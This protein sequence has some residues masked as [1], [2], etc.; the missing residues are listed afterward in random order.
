M[1]SLPPIASLR[2][3]FTAALTIACLNQSALAQQKP[4]VT[5]VTVTATLEAAFSQQIVATDSPTAF[6]AT[7]LPPGLSV[8]S[9]GVIS[10]TPTRAGLFSA[11]MIA[12]NAQGQGEATL[13]LT[14]KAPATSGMVDRERELFITKP[15]ILVK[16]GKE[17]P[18][19][20]WSFRA[21]MGRLAPKGADVN[22]FA[23]TWFDT[24]HLALPEMRDTTR[25]LLVGA[26]DDTSRNRFRLIGLV[27]RMDLGKFNSGDLTQPVALGESRLVYEVLQDNGSPSTFTFIFEFGLLGGA[28]AVKDTT[29]WALRW[30]ALGRASL[31]ATD[32]LD[33]YREELDGVVMDY[34]LGNGT[35]VKSRLNQI[36]TNEIVG[37]PWQ[38][39]EFHL[40]PDGS[41]IE[42][43]SVALT[44]DK[45]SSGT[46]ALAAYINNNATR[47]INGDFPL[48]L[49]PAVPMGLKSDSDAL[50][51]A[52]GVDARALFIFA[53]NTCGGCHKS[54]V[55]GMNF[56]HLGSTNA[57]NGSPFVTGSVT[58]PQKL[59]G[60]TS[61]VHDE[62][63]ERSTILSK[64]ALDP[65]VTFKALDAANM[66]TARKGRVH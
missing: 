6:A 10:G 65:A 46:A 5:P 29:D 14:V 63:A 53:F 45:I 8:N 31:K 3:C 51:N 66:L 41:R 12:I 59:P 56:Q 35:T 64:L 19:D 34:S 16:D 40:S 57:A 23:K 60:A 28:N 61:E 20:H 32:K 21:L 37:G 13:D 4:V 54:A 30:H 18:D 42:P 9:Y 7:G 49:D 48:P 58:L 39:R 55:P 17:G 50:W 27:N 43:A 44:P 1:K 52:N 26:W 2:A 25:N 22:A 36:R 47:I 62:M 33:A 11:T 24:W 15:E 38:L